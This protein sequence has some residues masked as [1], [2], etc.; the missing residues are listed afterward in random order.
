MKA[1]RTEI[2]SY[3]HFSLL[4]LRSI[5]GRLKSCKALPDE[6]DETTS[7]FC[8][9]HSVLFCYL[10]ECLCP[11]SEV[12]LSNTVGSNLK[13]KVQE[14]QATILKDYLQKKL[15]ARGKTFIQLCGDT[16]KR[17]NTKKKAACF[18]F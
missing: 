11:A 17:Q 10:C 14:V 1:E 18:H 5:P 13:K 16:Y 15:Q 6:S 3:R 7:Y 4:L 8:Q 2:K 9:G 12:V